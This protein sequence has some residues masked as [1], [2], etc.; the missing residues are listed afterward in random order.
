MF[1]GPINEP[2]SRNWGVSRNEMLG[3]VHIDVC[4]GG[5][6]LVGR[7]IIHTQILAI[8]PD[9]TS[10]LFDLDKR[11]DP[12]D[13]ADEGGLKLAGVMRRTGLLRRQFL[14]CDPADIQAGDKAVLEDWQGRS[15]KTKK[16]Q[17]WDLQW[18]GA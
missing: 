6:A 3:S 13:I 7:G 15:V 4:A 17:P 12:D 5:V 8:R 18:G 16:L 9:G 11:N 2:P 14:E 10:R 1:E